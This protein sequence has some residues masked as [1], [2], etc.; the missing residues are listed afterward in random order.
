MKRASVPMIAMAGTML[1][2]APALAI[3]LTNQDKSEHTFTVDRG[4]TQADKK[5][6]AGASTEIEC[7]GGCELRV[8]GSGYGR[9]V[10]KADKL[11]IEE[12]TLHFARE[13]G[14]TNS[15]DMQD[16]ETTKK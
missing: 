1:A 12:G 14:V 13:A 9:S 8:R 11:V 16:S 15:N 5:I 4:D 6:A 3:T 7:K 2:S 10:E